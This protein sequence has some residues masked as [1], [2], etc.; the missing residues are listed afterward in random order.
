MEVSW[1][2]RCAYVVDR[3]AIIIQ[4]A[5]PCLLHVVLLSTTIF[6]YTSVSSGCLE[7]TKMNSDSI[8]CSGMNMTFIHWL[9]EYIDKMPL[10]IADAEA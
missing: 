5:C 8:A 7:H 6:T 4:V 2:V 1:K 10:I 9:G 3:K